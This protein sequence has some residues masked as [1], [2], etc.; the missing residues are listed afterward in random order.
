[1]IGEVFLLHG[2]RLMSRVV[3]VEICSGESRVKL[4]F[5]A[6]VDGELRRVIGVAGQLEEAFTI[7]LVEGESP[8]VDEGG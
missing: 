1:M 6:S 5:L 7:V 8:S 4:R 3:L 2:L